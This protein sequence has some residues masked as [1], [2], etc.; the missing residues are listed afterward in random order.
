MPPL[1]PSIALALAAAVIVPLVAGSTAAVARPAPAP[2]A[3]AAGAGD[4]APL[5]ARA[6]L[7]RLAARSGT[8]EAAATGVPAAA[9]LYVSDGVGSVRVPVSAGGT[10]GTPT[11]ST[12][13]TDVVVG[14]AGDV[15]A[16]TPMPAADRTVVSGIGSGVSTTYPASQEPVAWGPLG[17]G[18]LQ[19]VDGGYV[20]Q[21]TNPGYTEPVSMPSGAGDPA[22]TPYGG[23]T[24]VRVPAAGG[25]SDLTAVPSPFYGSDH[26]S[27]TPIPLGLEQYAPGPPAV[28]QQPGAGVWVGENDGA[29]YLAFLGDRPGGGDGSHRL[30]VDHQDGPTGTALGY[31]A[32]VDV[33][34]AGFSCDVAAPRFSP[35][36]RFLA[37]VRAQDEECT[38]FQVRAVKVNTAGRFDPPASDVLLRQ[39]DT[40]APAPTVLSW[41]PANPVAANYRISGANRYEVAAEVA[42]GYPENRSKGVVLAGGK[43]FADAL[44]GGP[45]AVAVDG[46]SLLTAPDRL[47]PETRAAVQH[48]LEPGGTVYI[49]G[50]TASVSSAVQT[51]LKNLGLRTER[52]GGSSRYEVAVNVARKLDSLNGRPAP[53]AAFV[54]SGKAFADALVA[55]PPSALYDAPILLSNGPTLPAVTKSYLDAMADEAEIF[56]IGGSGAQSVIADPR[57][58]VVGGASRYDV[59]GNV[60]SRFFT[61]TWYAGIADGRNWPDA[62]AGG[63]LMATFGEPIL[64]TNGSG[65]LP[66]GTSTFLLRSRASA[67]LVYAFGGSASIPTSA[68]TAALKAAGDQ[69]TYYG[70]DTQP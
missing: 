18:F 34:D 42:F 21:A 37:Y 5:S 59:A 48:A 51:S 24:I 6:T 12:S 4:S 31:G 67:D 30:F 58:E 60:A 50:G 69:T 19:L 53:R 23:T 11:T 45:L 44:A 52:I 13:R 41:E 70:I 9:A 20:A 57:T 26:S 27:S 32:P 49:L 33:A 63:T 10:A 16:Y 55:G 35:D 38:R 62:V 22:I 61:S 3:D 15:I 43:A 56:A 17:D 36:R 28:D 64:L 65:T 47:R 54:A 46:P 68:F 7:A 1:R 29:T 39:V 25:G 40:G 8:A 66:A 14:P 2:Q